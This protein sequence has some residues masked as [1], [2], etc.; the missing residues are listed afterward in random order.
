MQR[1]ERLI[2]QQDQVEVLTTEAAKALRDIPVLPHF[3]EPASPSDVAKSVNMP[4]NLVHHHAKRALEL[5]LLFEAK[6]ENGKVYYQLTGRSFKHDWDLLDLE[7]TKRDDMQILS[8]AFVKAYSRSKHIMNNR[9]PQYTFYGFDNE[10][11]KPFPE[12]VTTENS[13]A[14]LAHLFSKTV[15]L[16]PKS[17]TRLV[18]RLSQ[19]LLETDMDKDSS[20]APCTF[21]L[22]AFDG[23]LRP[24]RDATET[25]DTF[26]PLPFAN[27]ASD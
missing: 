5:G 25:I 12:E 10:Y 7:E 23:V 18:Q 9:D 3:L 16:S 15:S 17:Y 26:V 4:A 24:G 6:R 2:M 13:S 19:L 27:R 21:T 11:K 14:R 22:L 8:D 1:Q 20:A